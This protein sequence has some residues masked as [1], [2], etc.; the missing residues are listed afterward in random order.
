M[1][2]QS[3]PRPAWVRRAV[4]EIRRE[5]VGRPLPVR[6]SWRVGPRKRRV[7]AL[8]ATSTICGGCSWPSS[9]HPVQ[10]REATMWFDVHTGEETDFGVLPR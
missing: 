8:F 6:V 3:P 4:V 10:G 7:T 2:A 9:A 5:F 1:T